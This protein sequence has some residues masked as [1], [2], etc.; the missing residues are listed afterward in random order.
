LFFDTDWQAHFDDIF[1]HGAIN[2][3]P[4][5][6]LCVPSKTDPGVAPK[7]SENLFALVPMPAGRV[8]T[9]NQQQ[10]V[11]NSVISRIEAACG[12]SFTKNIS[13]LETRGSEYFVETFN[14]YK[15]NAF[16]LSHTFMQ[17]GP[18]RPR[19]KSKKLSNL[20]YAGQYT[21][22]GTGVPMVVLSGKV[23]AD[24]VEQDLLRYSKKRD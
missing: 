12:E 3:K 6:Y 10:N 19:I 11:I 15:G 2:K 5:F 22:P 8:L 13:V 17:S 4:L 7:G 18:L 20:Y 9:K 24:Q 14:A 21:N 16:G 1:K 23:V